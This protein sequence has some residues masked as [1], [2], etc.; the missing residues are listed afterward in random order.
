M[1]VTQFM[2]SLLL[3]RSFLEITPTV[4]GVNHLPIVITTLDVGGE[5]GLGLLADLLDDA[6]ARRRAAA[7]SDF[8]RARGGAPRARRRCAPAATCWR[9][10]G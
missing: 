2:L 5:D 4:A 8:P 6:D 10:T 3:D 1:T 7:E 9:A